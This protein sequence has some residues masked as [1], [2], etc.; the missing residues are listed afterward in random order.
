MG[1]TLKQWGGSNVSPI[2]DAQLYKHLEPLSGVITGLALTASGSNSINVGAGWVVICGR[3]VAVTSETVAA[4]LSP[5]ATAGRLM[6]VIDLTDVDEPAKFVSTAEVA[7]SDLTQEDINN[8]GNVYQFEIAR[9]NVASTS[10]SGFARTAYDLPDARGAY[11]AGIITGLEWNRELHLGTLGAN[12]YIE[13][14]DIGNDDT[15]KEIRLTFSGVTEAA[16]VAPAGA[17]L[18]SDAG[19]AGLSAGN[20]ITFTA[21]TASSI[22]EISCVVLDPTHISLM[23]TE[24]TT[25]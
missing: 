3:V 23:Y 15:S 21:L 8:G 16:F 24:H 2:D 22:Y 18:A 13:L 10:I 1:L 14:P 12:P 11:P 25:E 19:F 20:T 5:T 6:I 7:Y 9:Y 4:T 17:I